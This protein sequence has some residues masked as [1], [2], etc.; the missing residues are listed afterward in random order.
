MKCNEYYLLAEPFDRVMQLNCAGK[1]LVTIPLSALLATNGFIRSVVV[2]QIDL[3]MLPI[4]TVR[5]V[6]M[7]T[8]L[9]QC[10]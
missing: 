10:C 5:D 9:R 6:W 3:G 4:S 8:Q 1:V 7:V 2:F